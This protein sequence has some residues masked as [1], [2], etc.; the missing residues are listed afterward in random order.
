MMTTTT[1]SPDT[2]VAQAASR[3]W[4]AL[5]SE[6]G[7]PGTRVHFLHQSTRP[8]E[9]QC[10]DTFT[11]IANPDRLQVSGLLDLTQVL[12]HGS[13]ESLDALTLGVLDAQRIRAE[14]K[15]NTAPPARKARP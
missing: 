9:A 8:T 4:C 2:E 1:A 3:L 11:A 14:R 6:V 7:S 12:V 5:I 10:K 13:E 15:R